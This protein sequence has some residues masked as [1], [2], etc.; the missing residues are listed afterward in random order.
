MLRATA[1]IVRHTAF[2]LGLGCLV[3]TLVGSAAAAD[4]PARK[5]GLWEQKMTSADPN[6]PVTVIQQCTDAAS[7][8]AFQQMGTSMGQSLCSKNDTRQDG[9]GWI[10]ESVCSMGPMKITSRALLTGDLNSA[11]RIESESK[12]EPAMM[13]KSGDKSIIEAKWV[14]ACKAGQVPGDMIMPNGQKINVLKMG[15]SMPKRP[16]R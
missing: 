5:A 11:Y 3:G 16:A 12:Y 6:A 14:G 15:E 10:T 9:A 8:K 13:G 1:P 4:L 7:E 2:I